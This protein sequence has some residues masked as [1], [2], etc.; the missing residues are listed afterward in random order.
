VL[1]HAVEVGHDLVGTEISEKLVP[2][3]G[4]TKVGAIVDRGFPGDFTLGVH[5]S[6]RGVLEEY[7]LKVGKSVVTDTYKFES[8]WA[9]KP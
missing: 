5:F 8:E 3:S 1:E 2:S 6:Y 9:I 4:A 7:P